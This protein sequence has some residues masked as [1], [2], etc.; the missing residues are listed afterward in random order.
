MLLTAYNAQDS[1]TFLYKELPGPK[2]QYSQ[3]SE[4]VDTKPIDRDCRLCHVI[5]YKGLE[6][7]W[8][9]CP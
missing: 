6:H 8:F 3:P 7:Q 4:F 5:L 9:C 1:P 2:G